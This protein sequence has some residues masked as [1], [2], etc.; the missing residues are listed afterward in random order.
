M[1]VLFA[2]L[3]PPYVCIEFDQT[4]CDA[5]YNLNNIQRILGT[6]CMNHSL[7]PNYLKTPRKLTNRDGKPR[8]N[9]NHGIATSLVSLLRDVVTF[10]FTTPVIV[11]SHLRQRDSSR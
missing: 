2:I 1:Q 8:P 5:D 3:R 10:E 4:L 6:E 11:S 9:N 7:L